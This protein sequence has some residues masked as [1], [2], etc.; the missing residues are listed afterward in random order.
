MIREARLQV[1]LLARAAQ[2]LQNKFTEILGWSNRRNG[3][4]MVQSPGDSNVCLKA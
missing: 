2:R 3:R 1:M 4:D